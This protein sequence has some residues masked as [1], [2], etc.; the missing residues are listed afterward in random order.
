[1]A[2]LSFG[3]CL[4]IPVLTVGIRRYT[5]EDNRGFAFGLFYVIMNVAAL[6]SG[7][8][9]DLCT[10]YFDNL[11]N[12]QDQNNRRMEDAAPAE[13]AFNGYRLI[14]LLG[15]LANIV[16]CLITISVKEIKVSAPSSG[17]TRDE[18]EKEAGTQTFQPVK[19]ST[20]EILR[21]TMRSPDFWRFLVVCMITLNIRM[22]FRH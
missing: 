8:T 17:S 10:I 3:N 16:A 11:K 22:I 13:W 14:I 20:M 19:T 4:G 15:I 21:E 18:D 2:L 7:P 6:L 12:D 9:V 5:N 1:M